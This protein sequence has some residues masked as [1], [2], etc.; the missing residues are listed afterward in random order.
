MKRAIV[1]AAFTLFSAVTTVALFAGPAEAHSGEL[2]A[3]CT[4]AT[5]T[6]TSYP[7]GSIL[8][9]KVD[10]SSVAH[11]VLDKPS[12]HDAPAVLTTTFPGTGHT[13]TGSIL[14]PDKAPFV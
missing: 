8:D 14:A 1:A 10:G 2:T 13:V 6:A 4:T 11:E 7:A 9:L 3:T 12:Y 5:L